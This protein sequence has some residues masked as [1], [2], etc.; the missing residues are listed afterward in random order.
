MNHHFFFAFKPSIQTY[1][2]DIDK[3]THETV[4]FIIET[5]MIIICKNKSSYLGINTSFKSNSLMMVNTQSPTVYSYAT[6]YMV[7][8]PIIFLSDKEGQISHFLKGVVNQQK[9]ENQQKKH[10]LYI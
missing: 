3:Q 4:T 10:I 1:I 8:D 2:L 6:I 5:E 7:D 9:K